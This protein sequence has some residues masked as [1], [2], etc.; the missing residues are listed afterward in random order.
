MAA[1]DKAV[2]NRESSGARRPRPRGSGLGG[3]D[4]GSSR[5]RGRG[6]GGQNH[7]NGNGRDNG[8]NYDSHKNS[9]NAGTAANP[10]LNAGSAANPSLNAGSAATKRNGQ[11]AAKIQANDPGLLGV[12]GS[13][14]IRVNPEITLTGT[15]SKSHSLL[16]SNLT[17]EQPGVAA[18]RA[19]D[20]EEVAAFKS[21]KAYT[22]AN[23]KAIADALEAAEVVVAN[24]AKAMESKESK[25]DNTMD[26]TD[27]LKQC[28]DLNPGLD[29]G[30]TS[31][32]R[33]KN[34]NS[35]RVYCLGAL[36]LKQCLDL[37]PGLDSGL[38]SNTKVIYSKDLKNKY[39]PSKNFTDYTTALHRVVSY[40]K[41]IKL[42]STGSSTKRWGAVKKFK[43]AKNSKFQ[44]KI[45]KIKFLK[46]IKSITDMTARALV[47]IFK[48]N[49]FFPIKIGQEKIEIF[50]KL[51]DINL[52]MAMFKTAL[53]T[54]IGRTNQKLG[55]ENHFL[56]KSRREIE[57]YMPCREK[58]HQHKIKAGKFP[59]PIHDSTKQQL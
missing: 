10:S 37:N 2:R 42:G 43:H 47:I 56:Q 22:D 58:K 9:L 25:E 55:Q 54:T 23:A 11:M 36:D 33:L 40:P 50:T 18:K 35:Y 34:S 44:N 48:C 6:R 1:E 13:S 38:T 16:V 15:T 4:I 7:G 14:A 59:T 20:R 8:K 45:Q 12:G 19:R 57:I 31:N 24:A 17:G 52:K 27:D 49:N 39:L 32:T 3:G 29:C 46:N 41:L 5:G 28:P 53:R 30:L 51:F 26:E 21:E